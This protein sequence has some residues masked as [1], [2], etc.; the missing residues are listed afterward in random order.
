[1][2]ILISSDKLDFEFTFNQ[3]SSDALEGL[4]ESFIKKEGDTIFG[5]AAKVIVIEGENFYHVIKDRYGPTL[6]G[7]HIDHLYDLIDEHLVI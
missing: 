4:R 5:K 7:E 1:M 2:L 6:I 3:S